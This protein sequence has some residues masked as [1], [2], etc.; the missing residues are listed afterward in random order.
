MPRGGLALALALVA[1]GTACGE[2]GDDRASG[3]RVVATTTHVSDLVRQVGGQR[4]ALRT[5]LR[6]GADPHDYEPRPSDA[7]AVAEAKVVFRSGGSTDSWLGDLG[8]GTQVVSLIDSVQTIEGDPHWW[9]DPRNAI[10][11]VRVVRTALTRADPA[12]REAY[13][14]RAAGYVRR[15]R[16]LDGELARCLARVPARRRRIVTTHESLRYL[17]RRYGIRVV[18]TVLPSSTTQAQ[19][20]ARGVDR[21]VARIK[22]ERVAAIF[23]ESAVEQRLERAVARETGARVADPLWVDALGPPGSGAETYVGAMRENAERL[24]EGMSA[25]RA[26]CRPR[27]RG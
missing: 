7:R 8:A 24:V 6:P 17:A 22:R 11:A 18:G 13:E 15:L 2:D 23:P 25:G 27:S 3:V 1:V 16:A 12:R 21:L 14:R 10:R 5:L 19:P 9:Q 4:I 20:S 26:S